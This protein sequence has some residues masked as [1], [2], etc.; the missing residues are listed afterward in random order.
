MGTGMPGPGLVLGSSIGILHG[1]ALVLGSGFVLDDGSAL[2]LEPAGARD[3]HSRCAA[4]VRLFRAV[5][6]RLARAETPTDVRNGHAVCVPDATR[7]KLKTP[8]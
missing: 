7:L 8:V 1:L 6:R 2:N 5:T 4:A 3:A